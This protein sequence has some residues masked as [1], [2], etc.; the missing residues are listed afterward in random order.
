MGPR[1]GARRAIRKELRDWA[2]GIRSFLAQGL[3]AYA[4]FNND[5][6]ADA[7]PNAKLLREIVQGSV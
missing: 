6:R 7:A 1:N 5:A 4:Y 3:D 2:R